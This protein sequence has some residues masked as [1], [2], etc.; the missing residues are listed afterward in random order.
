MSSPLPFRGIPCSDRG[1]APAKGAI[2]RTNPPV[3]TIFHHTAGHALGVADGESY[4]EAVSYARSVQ[5]SHFRNGWIDSGHNFL[6]TRGGWIFEGR[7]GSL[8]A[9]K[10]GHMVVSAHCPGQNDQPGIEHEQIDPEGM[11]QVQRAA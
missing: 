3:R 10:S 5:Q 7:H 2:A 9:V 4:Q 8:D 1:A 11:T 6:V